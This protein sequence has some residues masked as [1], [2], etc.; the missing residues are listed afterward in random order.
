MH[1]AF[2]F[3]ERA[4]SG[5]ESVARGYISADLPQTGTRTQQ[6]QNQCAK[7]AE[8]DAVERLKVWLWN[9]PPS[10]GLSFAFLSGK[11]Q[12]VRL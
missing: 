8:M 6:A 7:G 11:E 12:W 10:R 1:E 2:P 9:L 4:G 5:D 3:D